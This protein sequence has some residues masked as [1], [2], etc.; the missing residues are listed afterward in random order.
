MYNIYIMEGFE[1]FAEIQKELLSRETITPSMSM[2]EKGFSRAIQPRTKQQKMEAATKALFIG[3][4][5]IF[6][7]GIQTSIQTGQSISNLI[8][9]PLRGG[10]AT[11]F[12]ASIIGQKQTELLTE[13]FTTKE[14]DDLE[15][16]LMEDVEMFKKDVSKTDNE[17]A[18]D[19]EKSGKT[20]EEVKKEIIENLNKQESQERGELNTLLGNPQ[21]PVRQISRQKQK[22]LLVKTMEQQNI[23]QKN[24]ESEQY[25]LDKLNELNGLVEAMP[26]SYVDWQNRL[27]MQALR[28]PTLDYSQSSIKKRAL[29]APFRPVVLQ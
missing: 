10:T 18:E 19:A 17:V 22:M 9:D 11:A 6:K 7:K 27:R 14:K 16:K 26:D 21:L 13:D 2:A 28:E 1:T 5:G 12:I 29:V 24:Q 20:T 4:A 23:D 8:G 15:N 3:L 25:A